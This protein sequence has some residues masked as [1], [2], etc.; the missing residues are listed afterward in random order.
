MN[1]QSL[2]T[3]LLTMLMSMFGAKVF[4]TVTFQMPNADGITIYYAEATVTRPIGDGN[5]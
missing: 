3:I 5:T 2:I 4:A 1:K